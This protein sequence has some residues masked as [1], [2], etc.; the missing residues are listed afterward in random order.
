MKKVII[1]MLLLAV[2]ACAASRDGGGDTTD[3]TARASAPRGDRFVN[4]DEAKEVATYKQGCA[5]TDYS[6][7]VQADGVN[8]AWV[9]PGAKIGAPGPIEIL[10]VKNRSDVTDAALAGNLHDNLEQ[11]LERVGKTTGRGGLKVDSC[12]Y[13]VQRA[14]AARA[15]IPYAGGH[16]MQ[17]GIGVEMTIT[18]NSGRTVAKI[19]HDGRQGM[20]PSE[21]AAEVAD[22]IANFVRAH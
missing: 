6:N 15:W 13:W 2:S 3:R 14:D 10:K 8:W 7:L 18:D 20:A 1:T 21:A 11:A 9:D 4:S 17:A 16:M 5:I 22:D 19:R 12:I